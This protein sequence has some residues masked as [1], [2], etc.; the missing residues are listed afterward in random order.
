LQKIIDVVVRKVAT[1]TTEQAVT[2]YGK[3]DDET[4]ASYTVTADELVLPTFISTAAQNLA[5][6]SMEIL[7]TA[8][9]QTGYCMN[10]AIFS[11]TM[12]Y[13][14]ARRMN[15][16]CCSTSGA[17]LDSIM[18]QYGKAVV[19]DRRINA[20]MGGNDHALAIMPTALQLVTF[21]WFDGSEFG[22]QIGANY[23]KFVVRDPKSGLPLD[24]I[25]SDNCGTVTINVYAQ[26][27]VVGLPADIFASGDSKSGVKFVNKIK[28]TN[29]A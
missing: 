13:N 3:W 4:E 27:K 2:L 1:K 19:Y 28:V 25:I 10:P 29:L 12:L 20:A 18:Q 11:G 6:F 9:M 15:A 22:T 23:T 16:A 21:N 26:T 17:D 14:Y 7:E 8:L 5:P 24:V